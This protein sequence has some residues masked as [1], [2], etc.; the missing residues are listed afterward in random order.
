MIMKPGLLLFFLYALIFSSCTRNLVPAWYDT[1]HSPNRYIRL[2]SDGLTLVVENMEINSQYLVFD[3][4]VMNRTPFPVH[5]LPERMYCYTSDV[6]FPVG[7]QQNASGEYEKGLIKKYAMPER[8]VAHQID[9]MI[10]KQKRTGLAMGLLSAGLIIFDVAMDAKSVNTGE[11]TKKKADNALIRDVVTITGL[12]AADMVQE[13]S[14]MTAEKKGADLFYL[15]DE[16]LRPEILPSG[17]TCRGKIFFPGSR[18]KY[19]K[20][21]IPVGD[22]EYA[23]DFRFDW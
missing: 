9:A 10:K 16:M 18:G 5:V 6:P 19:F 14:F 20:L 23:F 11:W 1:K 2:E 17:G 4:E 13:A 22:M 3:V 15:Q 7:M 8:E 12:A 21:I